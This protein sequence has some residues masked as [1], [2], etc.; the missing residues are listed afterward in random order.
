MTTTFKDS[1]IGVLIVAIG[2]AFLY[3]A[4]E[5]AADSDDPFGP[6]LAPKFI[7][8]GTILL[9]ATQVA[10][11]VAGRHADDG[12]KTPVAFDWPPLFKTTAVI[13]FG[14]LHMYLF[15]AVGFLIATIVV[16][17]ALFALF[18][19]WRGPKWLALA[20]A[21]GIAFHLIFIELMSIY[22]PN[23]ILRLSDLSF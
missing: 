7:A 23:A 13:V 6:A 19:N 1:A 20:V 10:M 14:I 21:G 12:A 15:S 9:G 18:G 4:L 5:L 3:L 22:D 16:L 2:F 8:F 11:A 17:F